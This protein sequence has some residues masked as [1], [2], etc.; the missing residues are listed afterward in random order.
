MQ[1]A[2]VLPYLK[3]SSLFLHVFC[4]NKGKKETLECPGLPAGWMTTLFERLEQKHIA[5][6][7]PLNH[8]LTHLESTT[9][10][11]AHTQPRLFPKVFDLPPIYG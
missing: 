9:H 2:S 11:P 4:F 5:V 10:P 3:F 6:I 1:K 8:A 7:S